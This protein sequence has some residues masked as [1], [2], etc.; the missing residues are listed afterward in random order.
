MTLL[1]AHRGAAL[2]L[3]E[4][5]LPAFA[6]ALEVGAS[7]LELDVH[8]SRDGVLV[9]SH[10]PDGSRLAGVAGSIS[11]LDWS[12]LARWDMGARFVDRAG[13]RSCAGQGIGPP[14]LLDV[15]RAFPD[16]PLNVDLKSGAADEAVALIHAEGAAE[17]VCLASFSADTLRRVRAL[18]Y[19]GPTG[20]ARAEVARLL[21][22]PASAQRGFLRPRGAAAQLP[23]SLA[24][25]WVVARCHALSLRVD[26]W[27][28]NDEAT[29]RRLLA[30]GADGIMT[31][32]PRLLAPI[33]N[34]KQ[35]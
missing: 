8:R 31:D 12:E 17:R 19:K 28:V 32:D 4:N 29:A 33:L 16:V 9:V 30:L 18:G 26:F 6:R 20:M 35:S 24:R 2:E 23:L 22:L 14:R 1:Y 13:A 34:Y 3:P 11:D 25:P 10:D 7:A 15:L 5:T 27:T 21:A